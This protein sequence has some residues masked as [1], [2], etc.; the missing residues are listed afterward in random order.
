DKLL[1]VAG[2]VAE[3][4]ARGGPADSVNG[5]LVALAGAEPAAADAVVRGL[6]KG[7][8]AAKPPKLDAD[9]EKALAAL[10]PRLSPERRGVLVRLA[11]GWGSKQFATAGA[12]IIGAL[13]AK[14]A[15][16]KQTPEARTAAAAEWLGYASTDA[17][18]VTAI[19]D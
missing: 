19:L 5:V 11:T 17:Q 2:I 8:P 1:A 16:P 7:W 15:D 10:A 3:H 12:E 6:A 18:V 13:K 4:Y 14:L 9:A